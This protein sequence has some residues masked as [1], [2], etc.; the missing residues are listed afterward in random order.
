MGTEMPN[1]IIC[2]TCHIP[3]GGVNNKFLVLSVEDPKTRSV[4]CEVCH[5]RK[6]GMAGDASLNRFSHPLDLTPGLSATIP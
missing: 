3:H 6:P 2:E 5:T 1:Q 4:L